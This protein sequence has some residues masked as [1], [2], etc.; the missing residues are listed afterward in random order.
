MVMMIVV[1]AMIDDD[2]DG[3]DC[4]NRSDD[5]E[6]GDQCADDDG[7][8]TQQILYLALADFVGLNIVHIDLEG[9]VQAV[10]NLVVKV[11]AV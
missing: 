9:L 3:D 8:A 10:R 5:R 7:N 6:V 4:D 1:M 2:A 11:I